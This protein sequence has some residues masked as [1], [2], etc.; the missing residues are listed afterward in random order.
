MEEAR[1]T[2]NRSPFWPHTCAVVACLA[3][4]E[5]TSPVSP[6][7][8]AVTPTFVAT[9]APTFGLAIA[10]SGTVVATQPDKGRLAL[11]E[12][13]PPRF[14]RT[15]AVDPLPVDVAVTS[16][17]EWAIVA[18][19][20]AGRVTKIDLHT[21]QTVTAAA[22]GTEVFRVALSA[23]EARVYVTAHASGGK[24]FV[25]DAVTLSTI[26]TLP[27]GTRP[28][29]LT[30]MGD[31]LLYVGTDNPS[32][33]YEIDQRTNSVRRS[34]D[35]Q[36][37]FAQDIA[38]AVDGSEVYVANEALAN[39]RGTIEIFDRETLSRTDAIPLIGHAFGLVLSGDGRYLYTTLPNESVVQVIDR[40]SRAA[41]A[42]VSVAGRPRRIRL[43]PTGTGVVVASEGS[44]GMAPGIYVL[45]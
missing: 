10:S 35:L 13:S 37:A 17:G 19:H 43:D 5:S 44:S 38:I 45:R 9:D 24:L 28:N 27:I 3:C 25:L 34:G 4:G 29:S 26:A 18:Y 39:P 23:D 36:G 11:L 41:A 30:L 15:I 22:L 1:L 33:L 8:P 31:S 2:A 42:A 40:Q 7:G 12:V 16:A 14:T 32:R 6:P 20:Y 21:G